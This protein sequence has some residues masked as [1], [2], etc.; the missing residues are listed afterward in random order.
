MSA[1]TRNDA[2]LDFRLNSQAKELIERAAVLNG[3]TVSAFATATLLEKACHVVQSETTRH[4]TEKDARLFLELLDEGRPN[5]AFKRA[6]QRFKA[7]RHG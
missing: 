1:V 4:L 7:R 3:Q 5:A 2:R 6:A